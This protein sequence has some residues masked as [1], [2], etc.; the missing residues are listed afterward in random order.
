MCH[1][2]TSY[3]NEHHGKTRK[4]YMYILLMLYSKVEYC[5]QQGEASCH[6]F[7]YADIDAK[8]EVLVQQAIPN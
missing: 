8:I 1:S 5:L 3:I 4:N 7:K 6:T 2:F